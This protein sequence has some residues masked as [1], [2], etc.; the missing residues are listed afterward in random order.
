VESQSNVGEADW[1]PDPCGR[2]EHRYWDGKEWTDHVADGGRS[3]VDPVVASVDGP[4]VQPVD[5]SDDLET[6]LKTVWVTDGTPARPS[7]LMHLTN[8]RLVVEPT[9]VEGTGALGWVPGLAVQAIAMERAQRKTEKNA[10][11]RA[12][13]EPPMD[14][15]T[16]DD[17]LR[18]TRRAYAINY[19][20]IATVVLSSKYPAHGISKY[21][22]CKIKS[23]GRNVAL[24][25]H[26]EMFD[27]VSAVLTPMLPGRIT[28][29]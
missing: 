1:Y 19:A 5:V 25:F 3:S 4:P 13:Q 20:D 16:L 24:M 11:E 15:T 9:P 12:L 2:H 17:I 29:K 26:R 21:G 10:E 23:A 6:V 8:K 14:A 28:V 7:L 22:R 18:S 27:E